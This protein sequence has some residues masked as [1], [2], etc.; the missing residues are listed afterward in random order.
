MVWCACL[1]HVWCY[2]HCLWLLKL[3]SGQHLPACSGFC[4][5]CAGSLS[6]VR[7]FATLWTVACQVPLSMDFSGKNTGVGCRFFLQGIFPLQ[8]LNLHFLH[9]PYCRC[10]LVAEPSGKLHMLRENSLFL[11]GKSA[12]HLAAFSLLE[13]KA[14]ETVEEQEVGCMESSCR[15]GPIRV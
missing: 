14:V 10:S 6:G 2:S 5:A 4:S 11:S 12:W 7:P 15:T 1:I 8:G 3:L 9:L 13:W